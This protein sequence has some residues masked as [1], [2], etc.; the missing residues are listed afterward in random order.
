GA[1]GWRPS[2]RG[3][4]SRV[5][6]CPPQGRALSLDVAPS[7][8]VAVPQLDAA[9]D[10]GRVVDDGRLRAEVD[11]DPARVAAPDVDAVEEEQGIE[12]LHGLLDPRVPLGLADPLPGRVPELLVVGLA[13]P[14]ALVGDLQVRGQ[15]AVVEHGRAEARP[16]G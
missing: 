10:A 14:E 12:S 6:R 3:R 5:A 13:L 11:R 15:S 8:D 7:H 2:G 16:E 4:S 1:P 9:E